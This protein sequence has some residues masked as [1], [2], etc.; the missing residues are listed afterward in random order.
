MSSHSFKGVNSGGGGDVASRD[1]AK[2][3]ESVRLAGHQPHNIMNPVHSELIKV[4]LHVIG[5]FKICKEFL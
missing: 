3:Q 4:L 5:R 2:M 1:T